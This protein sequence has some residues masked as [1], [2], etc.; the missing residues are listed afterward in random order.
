MSL[1]LTLNTRQELLAVISSLALPGA[2]Q[3][4]SIRS[5]QLRQPL[6]PLA[7]AAAASFP[8]E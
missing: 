4:F 5:P 7:H 1:L 3:V 2:A 6:A 8:A